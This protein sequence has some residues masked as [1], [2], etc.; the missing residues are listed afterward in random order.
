M[1][2][3]PMLSEIKSTRDT[4]LF[5]TL[6]NS[7]PALVWVSDA[8]GD[9]V[10]FNRQWLDFTG[11]SLDQERGEGWAQGVHPD[12]RDRCLQVLSR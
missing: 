5:E 8:G 12:D 1:T 6:A 4:G 3:D 11:R 10:W 9:C 2:H 7:L